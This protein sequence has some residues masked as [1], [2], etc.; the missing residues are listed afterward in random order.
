MKLECDSTS[1]IAKYCEWI[2][3]TEVVD[4]I[5]IFR[6][7]DHKSGLE[8]QP[9]INPGESRR[10]CNKI[11]S[12]VSSQNEGQYTCIVHD[13]NNFPLYDDEKQNYV[14]VVTPPVLQISSNREDFKVPTFHRFF[15]IFY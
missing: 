5:N 12:N 4:I 7:N 6:E 2:Y 1:N 14:E 3:K 15:G 10:H 9:R 13:I 8:F 11:L